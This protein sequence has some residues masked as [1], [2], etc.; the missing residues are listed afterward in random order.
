MRV[1][2]RVGSI[3][4]TRPAIWD[5]VVSIPGTSESVRT[6]RPL[7]CSLRIRILVRVLL[8]IG[9]VRIGQILVTSGGVWIG[10]WV[11]LLLDRRRVGWNGDRWVVGGCVWVSAVWIV[12]NALLM[13]HGGMICARTFR[14]AK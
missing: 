1:H 7:S 13:R 4:W 6:L 5:D 14:M 3:P 2:V 11:R 9:A 10:V 12:R 8:G